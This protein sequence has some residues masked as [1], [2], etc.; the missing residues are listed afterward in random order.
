MVSGTKIP[1]SDGEA[2]GKENRN[3]KKLF[4]LLLTMSRLQDHA[5]RVHRRS[6]RR[7]KP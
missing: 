4:A 7:T 3:M 2:E 1:S 5:G 6:M